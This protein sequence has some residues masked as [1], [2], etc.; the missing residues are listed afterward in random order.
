ML[1]RDQQAFLREHLCYHRWLGIEQAYCFLHKCTDSSEQICRKFP[2]VRTTKVSGELRE[3]RNYVTEI[4]RMVMDQALVWSRQDGLDW[5][6]IVDPDEFVCPDEGAGPQALQNMVATVKKEWMQ[7]R[8]RTRELLPA[9]SY[10]KQPFYSNPYFQIVGQYRHRLYS[11]ENKAEEHWDG[12]LGHNQGQTMIRCQA[13]VRSYDAH[14]WTL[15]KPLVSYGISEYWEPPTLEVGWHAHYYAP[16]IEQWMNKFTMHNEYPMN[17]P[18]KEVV[19]L[20]APIRI[21]R[22]TVRY[23]QSKL[24]EL[25]EYAKQY[26]FRSDDEIRAAL[27]ASHVEMDDTLAR[28]V[29]EALDWEKKNTSAKRGSVEGI[30]FERLESL[31]DVSC[32]L[33]LVVWTPHYIHNERAS[34]F[35]EKEVQDGVFFNWACTESS[36]E[37]YLSSGYYI[38]RLEVL[39]CF[40]VDRAD[41]WLDRLRIRHGK[42]QKNRRISRVKISKSGIHQLR[43][44]APVMY[45]DATSDRELALPFVSITFEKVNFSKFL[46]ASA[47]NIGE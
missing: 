19:E 15:W 17:W 47:I 1:I 36:V 10:A 9:L 33:K 42:S 40:E 2:W 4:H 39:R 27:E 11:P 8:F 31:N 7:L 45:P 41:L 30:S 24:S 21:W 25:S 34:G 5:L 29:P 32:G 18:G 35:Y 23:Y 3:G 22:E 12:F 37:G 20:E 38:L 43:I 14:R 16:S 46:F 28:A 6:L 44:K 13:P 26:V